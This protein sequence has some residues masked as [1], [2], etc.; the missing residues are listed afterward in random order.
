MLDEHVPLRHGLLLDD[1]IGCA[2]ASC[3]WRCLLDARVLLCAGSCWLVLLAGSCWAALLC[4]FRWARRPARDRHPAALLGSAPLRVCAASPAQTRLRSRGS[5]TT[6]SSPLLLASFLSGARAHA[7][8]SATSLAA[9]ECRMRARSTSERAGAGSAGGRWRFVERRRAAS[10][11][12]AASPIEPM[13]QRD[14]DHA[15][16]ER[17]RGL[18]QQVR[19]HDRELRAVRLVRPAP[20]S[21]ARA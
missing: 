19:L 2:F 16:P 4:R 21:A 6:P 20:G 11:A 9:A 17:R 12:R 15:R 1:G 13:Q 7:A 18:G 10:L 5:D 14:G 3:W 8:E